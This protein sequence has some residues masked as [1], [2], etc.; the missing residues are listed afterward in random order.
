MEEIIDRTIA[1]DIHDMGSL[2]LPEAE[3]VV[4]HNGLTMHY[5]S[6]GN[7]EVSRIKLLMPG[8][9]A[10]SPRPKLLEIANALLLEGTASH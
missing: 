1:P 9:I 3:S 8:G 7:A 4:L 10:E 2:S 6:G 5:L